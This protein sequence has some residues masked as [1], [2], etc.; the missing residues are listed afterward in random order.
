MS[1]L[2]AGANG[3]HR[4]EKTEIDARGLCGKVKSVAEMIVWA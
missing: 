4:F 3:V 1:I 2:V